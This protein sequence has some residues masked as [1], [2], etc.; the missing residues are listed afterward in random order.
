MRY[1]LCLL[2]AR[3]THVACI[4]GTYT[5][6]IDVFMFVKY[7]VIIR[8]GM[9]KHIQVCGHSTQDQTCSVEEVNFVHALK[10]VQFFLNELLKYEC[11]NFM[12]E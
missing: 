9:S 4:D 12:N 8:A 7:Y 1:R 3:N 10:D 6:K 5:Y 11:P 2:V